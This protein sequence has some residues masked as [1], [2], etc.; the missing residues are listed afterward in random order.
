[1][2]KGEKKMSS[3]MNIAV[4]TN[5][6]LYKYL[7]VMLT[8]LFENN[9]ESDV[10]VYLLSADLDEEKVQIF[11][12]LAKGYQQNLYFLHIQPETFPVELPVNEKITREAYFRLALPELLPQELDRVLYLDVDIIVNQSVGDFYETDF[13]GKL[14]VACRDVTSVTAENVLKSPLFENLR[15]RPDFVYF[16]SG[17]LLMNLTGLRKRITLKEL[18]DEALDKS[19][20]LA[21]HDQDLLNCVFDGDIL[22]ADE[23]IYNLLARPAYNSGFGYEWVKE[24]VAIIHYA[25]SKPWTYREVHYVLEKF[26]WEYA[27]KTPLYTE[28]LEEIVL[29]EVETSC[30]DALF[31]SLKQENDELRQIVNKCM[32]LLQR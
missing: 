26:W 11:K 20:Y 12:E 7:Y 32:K 3:R 1:M 19:E 15:K 29:G 24:H 6:G 16:N 21:F 13:Q 14:F 25:G 31:R 2:E 28:L 27:K 23:K 8:S 9:K 4:A 5:R 22:A 18:M 30:M 10:N 17:V